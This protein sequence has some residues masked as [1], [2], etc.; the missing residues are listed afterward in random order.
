M[1]SKYVILGVVLIICTSIFTAIRYKNEEMSYEVI[2][3]ENAPK[4][5]QDLIREDDNRI[6]QREEAAKNDDYGT[7][8]SSGEINLGEV[9]YV[10]FVTNRSKNRTINEV[11]IIIEVGPDKAYG[12]GVVVIRFNTEYREDV[13]FPDTVTLVKVND[14]WGKIMQVKADIP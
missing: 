1:R 14:H 4:E 11:P 12:R 9:R 3:F 13:E 5:I 2:S 8:L 6:R 10:Y 7:I